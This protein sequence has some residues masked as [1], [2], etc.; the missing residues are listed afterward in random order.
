MNDDEYKLSVIL[1][2]AR[3]WSILNLTILATQSPGRI[4]RIWSTE[5]RK[6]IQMLY[7]HLSD[8]NS[9]QKGNWF[10]NITRVVLQQI[11]HIISYLSLNLMNIFLAKLDS[12]FCR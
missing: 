3:Q 1:F 10:N 8:L 2:L 9:Q 12:Y 5:S 6:F 11:Y 4:T 7:T